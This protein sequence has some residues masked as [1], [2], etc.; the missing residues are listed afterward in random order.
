[1]PAG[2]P[3]KFKTVKQMQKQI[4]AYFDGEIVGEYTITG[5]ALA[6]D[7]SRTTLMQY[8]GR[9]EFI[10]AIKRAKTRVENDYEL[11]LRKNGRAGDI[12]GLKNFGWKDK[13]DVDNSGT[14]THIDGGVSRTLGLLGEY[15]GKRPLDDDADTMPN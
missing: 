7:T 13:L 12:F 10:D 14:V 9:D 2:R 15:R 11:A 4:D 3:L 5:L 1:M 8:E 6:L